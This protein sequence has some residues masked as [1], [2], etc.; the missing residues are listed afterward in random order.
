VLPP[1]YPPV[2]PI[3]TALIVMAQAATLLSEPATE[4]VFKVVKRETDSLI[5]SLP[6][7]LRL[8][9]QS[10]WVQSTGYQNRVVMPWT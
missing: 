5:T 10:H 3:V 2:V 8:V 9:F 1:H 6:Q 4:T 7:W